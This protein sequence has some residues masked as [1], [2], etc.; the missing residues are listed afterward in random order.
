[1]FGGD[2]D[3][4]AGDCEGQ[5]VGDRLQTVAQIVGVVEPHIRDHTDVRLQHAFLQPT[6]VEG[7][8]GH[9]LHH[10][11]FGALAGKGPQQVH[12]FAHIGVTTSV[13]VGIG[14]ARGQHPA[15]LPVVLPKVCQPAARKTAAR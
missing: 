7:V 8:H 3:A 4:I 12:L 14:T 5:G 13:D 11:R 1:M 6:G 10:D 9:A 15:A 2:D